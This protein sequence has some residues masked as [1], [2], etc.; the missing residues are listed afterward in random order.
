MANGNFLL[1]QNPNQE[2]G[3]G[4]SARANSGRTESDPAPSPP[5][6]EVSGSFADPQKEVV[7]LGFH[8]GFVAVLTKK[9]LVTPTKKF[10]ISTS[11]VAFW[12]PLKASMMEKKG[13][14]KKSDH[15]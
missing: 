11:W 4:F 9:N 15:S 13:K 7:L 8:W 1:R 2:I 10:E 12:W 14:S 6:K 3:R 5:A